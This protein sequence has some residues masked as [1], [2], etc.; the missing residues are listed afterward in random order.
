MPLPLGPSNIIK[1]IRYS[2]FDN[3][4][5]TSNLCVYVLCTNGT[6]YIYCGCCKLQASRKQSYSVHLHRMEYRAI[7]S[8]KS[9]DR[10]NNEC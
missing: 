5:K 4:C 10:Y 8:R 7:L 3:N 1:K 6:L 9:V 2:R